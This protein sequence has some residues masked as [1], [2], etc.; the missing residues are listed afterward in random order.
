MRR[1]FVFVLATAFISFPAAALTV[2]SVTPAT[3][4]IAG[5]TAVTI[6]GTGFNT[7]NPAPTV[8]FDTTAATGVTVVDSTTINAISPAHAAGAVT[9]TVKQGGQTATVTFTYTTTGP[10]PGPSGCTTTAA[11]GF[12]LL[13]TALP[14]GSTNTFYADTVYTANAQGPVTYTATGL[15]PGMSI[16]AV[17]G[18]VS[19]RPTVVGQF[20][21]TVTA[22]D[23]T[24]T[25]CFSSTLKTSAAGGGGNAGATFATTSLPSG[26]VGQAYAASIS[27]T[28]NAGALIFGAAGLPPGLSIDGLSGAI[29]GT[30]SAAGTFFTT[31][32]VTDTGDGNK[33][34]EVVPLLILPADGSGF[35]FN[36]SIL[37]NGQLGTAYTDTVSISGAPGTV[38]FGA[39]GLPPGVSIDPATGKVSGTPTAA[40]TFLVGYTAVSGADTISLN[41]PVVIAPSAASLFHWVFIG[42][43]AS[44]IN[45]SYDR[46]PPII[47]AT[48]NPGPGGSVSYS[49]V[50]L[51]S[52]VTYNAGSGEI[53]GTPIEIGIYPVTFSATN[54]GASPPETI[55]I[56]LDF[57]VL[58]PKGGDTNS[59]PINLWVVKQTV[60]K[61]KTAATGS[62]QAQYI[63]NADRTKKN[64]FNAGKDPLK[65][66]LGSIPEIAINITPPTPK[67]S[68]T[69]SGTKFSF[70][71]AKGVNPAVSLA[72]D[73]SAQTI[74]LSGKNETVTDTLPGILG[75]TVVLGG[76][77]FKLDEFFDASGK[78]TAT[79]GYRKT[80]FV[81]AAA[82]LSAKTANKDMAQY[83][84]LLG[85]PSFVFPAVTS[86]GNVNTLQI[87]VFNG[88]TTVIDKTF[89]TL[90]TSTTST[91]K[92][93]QK[94]FKLKSSKDSAA[95]NTL[96]K[97]S[98]DSGSGKLQLSL[99]NL[100]LLP[101]LP[102]ASTDGVHTS[103]Q[104]TI[105]NKTY[106]TGLTIFAPK[107]GAYTT[108]I[109]K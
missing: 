87:Q 70:K 20:T 96:A 103:V 50:G 26:V 78:F 25:V 8:T 59:L 46:Q 104:L 21:V 102:S 56:T 30:P 64:I 65:I 11:S 17:T 72:L 69:G 9:V 19:G 107:A 33:V 51:P 57:I 10:G 76:K 91:S 35:K 49:A 13:T 79:S 60:K 93:G 58:P 67:N 86:N 98:Y 6:A 42:L 18:F 15:P 3:G 34:I 41:L 55:V 36:N 1:L 14:D 62:W 5:G 48:E 83:N 29:S 4:D 84:M 106:F 44:I 94:V 43:P 37:N 16:D 53:G 99:K 39:T 75:N 22:T 38:T 101:A 80:A 73:E 7:G 81:V 71:S 24:S 82:K 105:G 77:S 2:T 12:R 40:G 100:T 63:Y 97:F 27:I 108:K 54:S 32:T 89:T 88:S 31:L 95:T 66:S 90:V 61:G 85:D 45:K 52:G 92:T 47:L 28:G 68:L 74:K 23:G 109:P